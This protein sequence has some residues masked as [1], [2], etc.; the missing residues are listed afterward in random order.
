VKDGIIIKKIDKIKNKEGI[1]EKVLGLAK[2]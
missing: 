2:T 1:Y